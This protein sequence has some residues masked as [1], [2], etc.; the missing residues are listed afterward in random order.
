[1]NERVKEA[2]L[3]ENDYI[4]WLKAWPSFCIL[5]LVLHAN[6]LWKMLYFCLNRVFCIINV[7]PC[8]IVTTDSF[9]IWLLLFVYSNVNISSKRDAGKC[10]SS[11]ALLDWNINISRASQPFDIEAHNVFSLRHNFFLSF[12][13]FHLLFYVR[14]RSSAYCVI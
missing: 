10:A 3:W 1:M 7:F 12:W 5:V 4:I 14:V 9:Y 13:R 8:A 6:R 2:R 11:S